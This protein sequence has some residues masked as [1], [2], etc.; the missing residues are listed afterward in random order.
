MKYINADLL[1][2]EIE[3]AKTVYDN[4]NRVVHGVADAFRQD[5][6]AAMCDDI[7]KKIDSLQQE[8]QEVD[9]D[10]EVDNYFQGLWPGME[11]PEQCN[12]DMHFTPP[13]I[14]RMARHFYELGKNSK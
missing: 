13:A 7:L 4:P 12:T 6:R 14:M 9:L 5:G 3:F 1:R 11:T 8:Q 2:K 10:K